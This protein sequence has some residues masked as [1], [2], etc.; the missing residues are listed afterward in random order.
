MH[1]TRK[2]SENERER[3]EC[4]EVYLSLQVKENKP[5][6]IECM[7][8]KS[9]LDG[10]QIKKL[11]YKGTERRQVTTREQLKPTS[12]TNIFHP[13]TTRSSKSAPDAW[14]AALELSSPPTPKKTA[15][16]S[17]AKTAAS[18][19]PSIATN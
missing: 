16:S 17:A 18:N 3:G 14:T 5:D 2:H 15:E 19:P 9:T 1:G 7:F 10:D 8:C 4:W 6:A 11:A 13:D 12:V